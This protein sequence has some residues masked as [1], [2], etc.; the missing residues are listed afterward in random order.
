MKLFGCCWLSVVF[1][2]VSS[3]DHILHLTFVLFMRCIVLFYKACSSF[4][5]KCMAEPLSKNRSDACC[6]HAVTVVFYVFRLNFCRLRLEWS[7]ILATFRNLKGYIT[8]N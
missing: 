7:W 6:R 8:Y 2:N 5:F 3:I 4:A 1:V